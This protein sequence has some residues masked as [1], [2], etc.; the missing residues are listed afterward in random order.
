M[1]KTGRMVGEGVERKR[2]ARELEDGRKE[3]RQQVEGIVREKV[4]G[5]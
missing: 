3:T 5:E 1:E 2:E 4:V